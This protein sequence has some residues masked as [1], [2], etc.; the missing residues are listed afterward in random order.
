MILLRVLF[1]F[2]LCP[3]FIHVNIRTTQMQIELNT[4]YM[5]WQNT[6]WV[7][8]LIA[9]R[10]GRFIV[11]IHAHNNSSNNNETSS[12]NNN[13]VISLFLFSLPLSFIISV[14]RLTHQRQLNYMP[15]IIITV[16][17]LTRYNRACIYSNL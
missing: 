17:L 1:E 9:T 15:I 7:D 16:I 5:L 2:A 6:Q 13:K 11:V 12:S 8:Q 10:Q 4:H 3:T 14:N